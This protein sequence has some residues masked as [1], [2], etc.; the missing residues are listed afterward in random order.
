MALFR[1]PTVVLAPPSSKERLYYDLALDSEFFLVPG[2]CVVEL[3]CV[4]VY[5]WAQKPY[6]KVH[7][8][9]YTH[10][11][12]YFAGRL[13]LEFLPAVCVCVH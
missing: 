10:S 5:T 4:E 12:V 7:G 11:Q 3:V 13:Y 2:Y 8:L 1:T 9:A 6:S